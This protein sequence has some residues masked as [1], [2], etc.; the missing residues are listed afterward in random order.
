VAAADPSSIPALVFRNSGRFFTRCNSPEV[1][2]AEIPGA[3]GITNGRGLAGLY[4][5]LARN[6]GGLVSRATVA[7]MG[8]VSSA[9]GVDASLLIPTRFSLGFMK[10]WDNRSQPAEASDS[11]IVGEPAF[12]HVGFGG[13]VGFADPACGLAF[14]YALN[15]HG[16]RVTVDERAQSLI[17]ATYR[18]LG[19]RTNEPGAWIE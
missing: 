10:A 1:W 16:S 11:F 17:D 7:R 13:S 15:R 9:A 4:A 12:G 14:G 18:C 2:A 3:N 19:Y 8:A 6:D 5:A